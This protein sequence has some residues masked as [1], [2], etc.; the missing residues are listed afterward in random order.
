MCT[1][2]RSDSYAKKHT[3]GKY[4]QGLI[5]NKLDIAGYHKETLHKFKM[6]KKFEKEQS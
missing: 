4:F 3:T 5:S 1:C 6:F 2:P